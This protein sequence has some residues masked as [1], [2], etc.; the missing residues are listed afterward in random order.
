MTERTLSYGGL[1]D[2]GRLFPFVSSCAIAAGVAALILAFAVSHGAALLA[3]GPTYGL[4]QDVVVVAGTAPSSSGIEAGLPSSSLTSGDVDA[5]ANAAFVPGALAV[6]PTVGVGA[7]VSAFSRTTETDVIGTTDAFANVVGYA[8]EQGRFLTTAD[9]QADSPVVVLG[10][11]VVSSLFAGEN[12]VGQNVVIQDK[13]FEVVGTLR[14]RGFSDTYNQDNLVIVPI[15][16]A[17]HDLAPLKSASAPIDQILIRSASPQA[18]ATVS[19]EVTNTLLQRHGIVDP[20]L[21]D[22]TVVTQS[23]LVRTEI[24]T[25][26]AVRR[27]FEFVGVAVLLLGSL[28]LMLLQRAD[29]AAGRRLPAAAGLDSA[30]MVL[31]VALVGVGVGVLAAVVLAPAVQHLSTNM[32]PAR[33]SLYG[34]L[35]GAGAGVAAAALSIV[36]SVSV[37]RLSALWQR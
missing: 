37:N 5:V 17:W 2:R 8:I 16:A 26:L 36:V 34:V 13:T 32:P 11:T 31:A 33:P 6:A 18:A 19:R 28:Q 20:A 3:K 9:V 35:A 21:A 10:Q 12:P 25:A 29:R 1:T 15:T 4:N 24:S 22:F 7:R 23:Q 14:T 27:L 30:V